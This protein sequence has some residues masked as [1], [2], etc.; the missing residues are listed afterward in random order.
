MLINIYQ[1]PK[2]L[3]YQRFLFKLLIRLFNSDFR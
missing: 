1:Q 3:N 2:G